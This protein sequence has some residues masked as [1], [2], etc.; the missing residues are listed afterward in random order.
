M[1]PKKVENFTQG[2]FC[3]NC[4]KPLSAPVIWLQ[5]E[6]FGCSRS[7]VEKSYYDARPELLTEEKSDETQ[8]NVETDVGSLRT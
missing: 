7:C 8:R 6:H 3:D 2:C 4:Q 5:E 1:K